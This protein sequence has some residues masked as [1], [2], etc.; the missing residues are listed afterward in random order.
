MV[1]PAFDDGGPPLLMERSVV[2]T[3]VVVAVELL[4][5]AVG[6]LTS[7]EALAVLVTDAPV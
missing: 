4:F 5:P 1:W 3:T 6:S 7:E 2:C